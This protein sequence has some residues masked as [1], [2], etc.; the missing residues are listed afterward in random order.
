MSSSYSESSLDASLSAHWPSHL[1]AT[2]CLLL[3]ETTRKC[4]KASGHLTP[5]GPH[6]LTPDT[7]PGPAPSVPW[8]V[9][10]HSPGAQWSAAV[11]T[12]LSVA[13]GP[14]GPA[15]WPPSEASCAEGSSCGVCVSLG[16]FLR[17]QPLRR[18]VMVTPP[19]PFSTLQVRTDTSPNFLSLE[20][21]KGSPSLGEARTLKLS[22]HTCLALPRTGS[23]Q[24]LVTLCLGPGGPHKG[25]LSCWWLVCGD[26]DLHSEGSPCSFL[27]ALPTSRQGSRLEGGGAGQSRPQSHCAAPAVSSLLASFLLL[28]WPEA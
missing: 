13:S 23:Q 7:Q 15:A 17:P 5:A 24:K 1:P 27:G 3:P 4:A 10:V 6:L 2:R 12:V 11:V 25:S 8:M 9:P 20:T 22:P 26:D 21:S 16:V 28:K 14:P 19:G 18:P